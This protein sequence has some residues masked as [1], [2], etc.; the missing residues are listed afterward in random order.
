MAGGGRTRYA[1]SACGAAHSKWLGQCPSCGEWNTLSQQAESA[2]PP[3]GGRRP[4]WGGKGFAGYAGATDGRVVSL[5]SVSAQPIERIATGI[6]ELD[7]VLGG[8]FAEG[9]TVLLGGNPG[10]GK[11]TLLLQA[12]AALAA[13]GVPVLYCTGEESLSQIRDRALRLRLDVSAVSASACSSVEEI[14]AAAAATGARLLV[15]DSVQTTF[16]PALD[17]VPGGVAQMKSTTSWLNAFAKETGTAVVMVGHITKDESLAGPM[18][19]KHVVD[20]TL[21]LSSTED[22][23]YRIL[24]ADKNRFG[25]ASEIGVFAMTGTGMRCVENPGAIF[26]SRAVRD[27]PGSVVT[28][29]WEGSRPLLVEVQAL[30]DPTAQNN[31]RRVSVGFDDRRVAML[32]AVLGHRG[33]VAA[34]GHD[35]YANVVGGLEVRETSADLALLLAFLSSMAD[36]PVSM[37]TVC[38]GEVGLSGEVRPCP[39]GA[40]RLREAVK[41][42]MRRAIVPAANFPRDGVAGMDVVPVC[43]VRQVVEAFEAMHPSDTGTD[44]GELAV[45]DERRKSAPRRWSMIPSPPNGA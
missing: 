30:L 25:P 28:A 5:A 11:S 41:L 38:F 14:G 36:R 7:R 16:N 22:A 31:P 42:G 12:V 15:V 6:A 40:E 43:T 45:R 21:M 29:L 33:G 18:A 39:N 3:G 27:A 23:R 10:A 26:L 19:V 32:V 9:M 4:G 2:A 13:R 1:C 24:R 37:D 17:S 44:G 8:G 34:S 35:V 20:A